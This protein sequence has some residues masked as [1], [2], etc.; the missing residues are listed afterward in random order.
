MNTQSLRR[1]LRCSY[2]YSFVLTLNITG[3]VWVA[4]LAARGYSLWQIGAAEGV[5]HVVSL[6]AEVPSGMAADLLGR[7]R[8]LALSGV[9]AALSGLLMAF[10][11]NFL[12]VCVAMGLSALAYNLVSGTQE[13]LVYDSLKEV[14]QSDRFFHVQTVTTQVE[15]AGAALGKLAG[16]LTG[17]LSFTGFYLV[18][19]VIGLLRTVAA[20][21]LREP[22][23]TPEQAA[24]RAAPLRTLLAELPANLRTHVTETADFLRRSPRVVRYIL[25]GAFIDLPAFLTLMYLQQRLTDIGLPTAWLGAVLMLC[26]VGY[27]LGSWIGGRLR[28][29]QMGRLYAVCVVGCGLCTVAMGAAPLAGAVAG[30]AGFAMFGTIWSLHARKRLNDW[31]P[32]DRRATLISVDSMAYSLLMIPASPLTGWIGDVAGSAGAG[33]MVLG[34]MLMAAGVVVGLAALRKRSA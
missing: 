5:F 33:L 13:A 25:A 34:M 11:Q 23:V 8:V 29:R 27:P 9:V 6:L 18:D 20:V 1:Q 15:T 2:A 30:G 12:W 24:R 3:A 26:E 16:A 28:P 17:V 14:N 10:E 31:F 32:S 4:L 19:T 21:G 22:A 7:R